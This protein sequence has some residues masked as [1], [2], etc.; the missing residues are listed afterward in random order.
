MKRSVLVT[1]AAL[2]ALGL[3]LPWSVASAAPA[4]DS[5]ADRAATPAVAGSQ[6]ADAV[7]RAVGLARSHGSSFGFDADQALSARDVII[8]RDGAQHVRFDRTWKTLP[9]LGG[10]VV[11]HSNPAGQWVAPSAAA[12]AVTPASSAMRVTSLEAKQSLAARYPA[13]ASVSTPE[14]VV[15]ALAGPA[16][17]AWR[18]TVSGVGGDQ[19]P[20]EDVF[21][22]DGQSGAL[23]LV[24]RGVKE[25]TGTSIYA[26]TV[27]IATAPTSGGFTLTDTSRGGQKTIDM[28]NRQGGKGQA[29]V[30]A[31]DTW[32]DGATSSRQSAAVDAH[33]GA[34]KTWDF[35]STTYRR[36]GIKNNGLGAPSRVHYGSGYNNA[37][38]SDSCFCMTYGDG[39]NN[40]RPLVSIDVAG[41][42]MTH[43]VTSATAGLNYSGDAGGLNESTSDIFGA[44]VEFTA[45]NLADV[46]DYLIG[47]KI[48]INGNGT[49]LRYL[50]QPSKDGRSVDCWSTAV[51]GLD[52]HYSSGVGNHLFYLLAEGSGAKTV[53]GVAYNSPTCN[54][55]TTT[56]IGRDGASAIWY[57]ALTTY[58]TSTTTYPQARAATLRAATDLYGAGSPQYT[59]TVAAWGAV[60]VS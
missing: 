34:E 48:N 47:E 44:M 11:V 60:N 8:D 57:R 31:D 25:G 38:W 21:A 41:H 53:N 7:N 49:P 39:T 36:A 50:D 20:F 19:T 24:T 59:A 2:A 52:P 13:G 56:G 45:N 29:F 35:Y 51:A 54:G 14:R 37:F 58:M 23:L 4:P 5:P 16:A 1:V 33:Y 26:G 6:R 22:V 32:G 10:D 28:L 3:S 40:A 12:R 18:A 15:D 30:D 42:E 27:P 9:V 43:G 55:A 17:M 46:G